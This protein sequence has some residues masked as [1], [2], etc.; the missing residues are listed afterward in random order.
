[1]ELSHIISYIVFLA[2]IKRDIPHCVRHPWRAAEGLAAAA[3][4]TI[5]LP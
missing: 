2:Q 1:L 5:A 4:V 3:A